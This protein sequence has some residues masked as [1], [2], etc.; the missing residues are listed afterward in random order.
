MRPI[1]SCTLYALAA[2]ADDVKDAGLKFGLNP[3]PSGI[4]RGIAP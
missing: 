1:T 3:A 4:G 2:A